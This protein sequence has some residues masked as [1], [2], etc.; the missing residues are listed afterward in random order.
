[1]SST[2]K[3]FEMLVT[4]NPIDAQQALQYGLI[5]QVVKTTQSPETDQQNLRNQT[6]HLAS[7]IASLSWE[8]LALGKK[9]KVLT[10]EKGK[11]AE[12]KKTK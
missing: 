4:G 6:R 10:R 7:Q 9:V 1:M 12:L 3:L 8:T 5:N 2:K 11:S